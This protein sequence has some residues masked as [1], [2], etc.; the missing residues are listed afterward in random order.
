MIYIEFP[1]EYC[2]QFD[3]KLSL[4]W[5]GDAKGLLEQGARACFPAIRDVFRR[6][7]SE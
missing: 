2:F 7:G 1:T 5:D 3:E 4:F 6:A